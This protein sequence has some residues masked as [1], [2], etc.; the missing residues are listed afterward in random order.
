MGG[1]VIRVG[2]DPGGRKCLLSTSSSQWNKKK[3]DLILVGKL[4]GVTTLT[5]NNPKKLNGWTTSMMAGLRDAMDTAAKDTDTKV[6]ILT[7]RSLNYYLLI[8]F[9]SRPTSFFIVIIIA[10][11]LRIRQIIAAVPYRVLH[12]TLTDCGKVF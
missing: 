5:M 10:G 4:N 9:H 8:G 12:N 2:I 11:L 6:A 7:G 3:S 1:S